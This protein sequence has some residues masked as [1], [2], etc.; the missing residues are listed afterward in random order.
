MPLAAAQVL[1]LSNRFASQALAKTWDSNTA[2]MMIRTMTTCLGT[3][4]ATGEQFSHFR[5]DGFSA[6]V[7]CGNISIASDQEREGNRGDGQVFC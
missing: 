2:A 7:H 4:L 6:Y 5:F 1:M 3:S